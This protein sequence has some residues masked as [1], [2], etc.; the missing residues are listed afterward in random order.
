M[1]PRAP[2]AP[3]TPASPEL[4]FAVLG[5]LT[6]ERDGVPAHLGAVMERS[7]L[8]LLALLA[9]RAGETVAREE[10]IDALW[11]E[12][13]PPSAWSL[14]HSHVARLRRWIEP[15]RHTG[16]ATMLAGDEGYRLQVTADRLDLLR[17]HQAAERAE[18]A[19]ARGPAAARPLFAAA[20]GC[21]RG[22][23]LSDLPSRLREHPAALAATARRIDT[24]L[25]HA[26]LACA[27]GAFEEA[28][29]P[30]GTLAEEEPLH[31]GLAARLMLT[32]A[33]AG[34]PD[35]ALEVYETL[36]HRLAE[37]RATAPGPEIERA[38]AHLRQTHRPSPSATGQRGTYAHPRE[39]RD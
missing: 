7:L 6:V 2:S 12:H 29:G 18:A 39:T 30:L 20:L 38:Y 8:A 28:L 14:V 16:P 25:V 37:E 33:A 34:R 11:G 15:R 4:R 23:V 17:F 22:P 24:A 35:P 1:P 32:L 21:W 3:E 9:L 31:E 10:V 19:Y 13:P 5:P 36:R 27:Q 26:E